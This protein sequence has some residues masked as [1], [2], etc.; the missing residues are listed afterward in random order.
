MRTSL[1][2]IIPAR[3][4]SALAVLIACAPSWAAGDLASL[5]RDY[6]HAS[7][8]AK[9]AAIQSYAVTRPR[10]AAAAHLALGVAA[11]E[12]KDYATA[13]ADLKRAAVPQLADYAAYYAAAARVELKETAGVSEQLAAVHATEVRSPL[14]GRAWLLEGR[15]LG[16][17]GVTVLRAHYAE[18]PQPDGDL[19]LADAYQ[20]AG[21]L[22]Q[23]ADFYQRVFYRYVAGEPAERSAAAILAL[24]ELMGASYPAPLPQQALQRADRL[25]EARQ[26]TAARSEYEA[27]IEQLVGVDRDIARV[28]VGASELAAGKPGIA[29]PYLR[30]LELVESEADAERL[31]HL[32]DASRRMND[33]SAIDASVEQLERKYPQSPWRLKALVTAANRLLIVNRVKDYLPLYRA[34]YEDFPK[35]GNAGLYH[36]KV[37]FQAYLHDRR[38][39][40]DLLREH[41]RNYPLH[42]TTGAAFYFLGRH[43]ERRGELREARAIYDQLATSFPNQFY[44]MQARERLR[45]PEI[46]GAAAS[47]DAARFLAGL[48]MPAPQPVPAEA[49]RP[50]AVRIERSR[51]LRAA[52]LADFADA[53]LRYGARNDGQPQL[54][55]MEIA[56]SAE[57]E[58]IA[59][60]AMKAFGG[61]YLTL[62]VER[63][64]RR[65]WEMLFPLPYRHDIESNARLRGLDPF[66]VAGLIRQESEFN[67][68]ARS[69]ANAYGLMQVRPGTGR[70]A[71]RRAGVPRFTTRMLTQSAV[72]VRLGAYILRGMLDSHGGRIEETLASYNAGPSRA[73]EWRTWANFREP[74]E[75]IETIPFTETRDYVQAVLRNAEMY[76]RLYR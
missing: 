31:Y 52:G 50:T 9:R 42:A 8:P 66:L 76:R 6:R 19:T 22:A 1:A 44:A 16:A 36:W 23:A 69:G 75:F 40:D 17:A 62:P 5:V 37:T 12:H 30:G 2:K 41:L 24:K 68:A 21:E 70:D 51:L 45:A 28:R 58:H 7:T 54:L 60:R 4:Y 64:P 65:F 20:A 14:T 46:A 35:D 49:T 57:S 56:A 43:H 29:A 39:A 32:T 26:F 10:E 47:E 73:A 15:A 48:R 27:L 33:E 61:D 11:F 13:I 72:N 55:G 25:L 18:L 3:W 59:L 63:A 74:A 67:P 71:S 53:E 38:D 34:A